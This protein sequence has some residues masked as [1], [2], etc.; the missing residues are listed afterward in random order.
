MQSH[1]C[2]CC[3]D[4]ARDLGSFGLHS[5]RSLLLGWGRDVG[6]HYPR[7]GDFFLGPDVGHSGLLHGGDIR[8]R[9]SG[10]FFHGHFVWG[11]LQYRRNGAV[12]GVVVYRVS[13][14]YYESSW[15]HMEWR[16]QIHP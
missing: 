11:C 4:E 3:P 13:G 9:I 12:I 5:G 1:A 15:C 7:V 6:L 14:C 2:W 10:G 8:C 16:L